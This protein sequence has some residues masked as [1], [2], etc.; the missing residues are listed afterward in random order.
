LG[1]HLGGFSGEEE[2]RVDLH[3]VQKAEEGQNDTNGGRSCLDQGVAILWCWLGEARRGARK[4]RSKETSGGEER[5]SRLEARE[6][7]DVSYNGPSR[8]E[9]RM[10]GCVHQRSRRGRRRM[11][12][13]A[14]GDVRTKEGPVL[15]AAC[16]STPS[17]LTEI[18]VPTLHHH[19]ILS[20]YVAF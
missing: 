4:N 6:N 10:L 20:P 7:R 14:E 13:K 15:I 1:V 19:L 17:R 16:S 8:M 2:A 9:L 3:S 18:E 11:A 12:R 5:T